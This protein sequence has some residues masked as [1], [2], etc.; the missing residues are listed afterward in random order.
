MSDMRTFQFEQLSRAV[1]GVV[2]AVAVAGTA[3]SA[4]AGGLDQAPIPA[5]TK[6]SRGD[7]LATVLALKAYE[8]LEEVENLDDYEILERFRTTLNQGATDDDLASF[9]RTLVAAIALG[10]LALDEKFDRSFP[11]ELVKMIMNAYSDPKTDRQ[12]SRCVALLSTLVSRERVT[13]HNQFTFERYLAKRLPRYTFGS[14]THHENAT[15]LTLWLLSRLARRHSVDRGTY[16]EIL[17]Y[18][19]EHES[20]G[21][22]AALEGFMSTYPRSPLLEPSARAR[23]RASEPEKK[24]WIRRIVM[25]V[26]TVGPI[27]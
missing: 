9:E 3:P 5:E 13:T 23:K 20:P 19:R 16:A 1:V 11:S 18:V 4:A 12:A 8:Y 22:M 21:V 24:K 2:C 17:S 7:S 10:A 6:V 15:I 27:W 25:G 14:R 26:V